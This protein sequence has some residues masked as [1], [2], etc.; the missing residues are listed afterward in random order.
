MNCDSAEKECIF[1]SV[2]QKQINALR[3]VLAS[4]HLC[5]TPVLCF[6]KRITCSYSSDRLHTMYGEESPK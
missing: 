4:D 6:S 3:T 1:F 5:K 2:I